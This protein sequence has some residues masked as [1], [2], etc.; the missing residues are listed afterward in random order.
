METKLTGPKKT[1]LQEVQGYVFDHIDSRANTRMMYRPANI[2]SLYT[3]TMRYFVARSQDHRPRPRPQRKSDNV[4][5]TLH[6]YLP[7][8]EQ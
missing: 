2:T 3:T 7:R 8:A 6:P 5:P 4:C 1:K